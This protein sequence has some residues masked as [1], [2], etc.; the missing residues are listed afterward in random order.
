MAWKRSSV[1]SRPGPPK[2]STIFSSHRHLIPAVLTC[3][4]CIPN[5]DNETV[6][7]RRTLYFRQAHY[8]PADL[9][10]FSTWNIMV[11]SAQKSDG[12]AWLSVDFSGTADGGDRE[13]LPLSIVCQSQ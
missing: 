3:E 6:G 12:P 10:S 8:S 11:R 13:F 1:R 7:L 9:T 4:P 5:R 2:S